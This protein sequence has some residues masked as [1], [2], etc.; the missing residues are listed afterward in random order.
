MDKYEIDNEE[1]FYNDG[2]ELFSE[3]LSNITGTIEDV[4]QP[5]L[6][7]TN[8]DD[9][10][11]FDKLEEAKKDEKLLQEINFDT[12]LVINYHEHL[13][14]EYILTPHAQYINGID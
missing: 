3:D 1:E 8:A 9:K 11:L 14:E 2:S 7:L 13:I 6:D 4:I 10:A 5:E 12:D